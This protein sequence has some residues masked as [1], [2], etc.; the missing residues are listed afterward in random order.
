MVAC[1]ALKS[2]PKIESGKDIYL[3]LAWRSKGHLSK[4]VYRLRHHFTPKCHITGLLK[5]VFFNFFID[6]SGGRD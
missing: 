5:Y 6:T 1:V 2:N 3:D 4:T